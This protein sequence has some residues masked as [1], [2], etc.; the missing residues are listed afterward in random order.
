MIQ[1][2][3]FLFIAIFLTFAHSQAFDV[4]FKVN[5]QNVF[6]GFS[7]PEVNGTFNSWCGGCNPMVDPDGDD[8]WEVT[9]PI[10]AG[11]YQYKFA[12]DNWSDQEQLTAGSAC[13]V[14]NFGFTNRFLVVDA[15]ITLPAV[16]WASCANC[17]DVPAAGVTFQ[18][19]MSGQTVSPTGVHIAGS[20]AD[21]NSD[22][23]IDNPYPNWDPSVLALTDQGNG[24]WSITL[25][26]VAGSY[27]YKFINGNVWDISEIFSWDS[28]CQ[29]LLSGNRYVM[30]ESVDTVLPTVC[31][32]E[33]VSCDMIGVGCMDAAACNYDPNATIEGSCVYPNVIPEIIVEP[34]GGNCYNNGVK[35]YPSA[36]NFLQQ[37]WGSGWENSISPFSYEDTLVLTFSMENLYFTATDDGG[38]VFTMGPIS[39]NTISAPNVIM[40]MVTVN[41]TTGKNQIVW[42]PFPSDVHETVVVF[43][44]SNVQGV[45]EEIG[46]APYDG[47]GVFEDLNSNPIIQANRY[48]IGT[49]DSCGFQTASVAALNHKTIHLTANQGIGNNINLIW[50]AYEA[51]TIEGPMQ[52]S[53]Y[54]IYRGASA[55]SLSLIATVAGNVLSYTDIA[56][57]A[58]EFLYVIEVAGL[59]CDPSR[60]MMSSR[61]NVMNLLAANI[62][63]ETNSTLQI[64]PNPASTQITFQ[65][66]ESD[67]GASIVVFNALGQEVLAD[68]LNAVN[69]TLNIEKLSEGFYFIKVEGR[70]V[71]LQIV[72]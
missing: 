70:V 67:L 42:D 3:L 8:I 33:C 20:F 27:Q 57:P 44:E 59:G 43:K 2:S 32:N 72:K 6:T 39:V 13:T 14:T 62:S 50:T 45:Y 58:A 54:N 65:V 47:I 16:C 12:Y 26:L 9:I 18:V 41:E 48:A 69:Q 34:F 63:E 52:I 24:I 21:A 64:F 22:G 36:G 15:D 46:T 71:R 23:T 55:S 60:E 5:M 1:R 10:E 68:R 28:N 7:T 30:V 11:S 40:C 53:S 38:C 25:D 17:I 66:N 56:P 49:R 4:T 31:W 29:N 51:N 35:V 37:S 61:S 19:D